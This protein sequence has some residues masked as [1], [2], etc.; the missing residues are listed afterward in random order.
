MMR[1]CLKCSKVK[2][3]SA[4]SLPP[5]PHVPLG[6][7]RPELPDEVK[8]TIDKALSKNPLDRPE[9]AFE[10][11]RSLTGSFI[12]SPT[13]G[14]FDP[15]VVKGE[16]NQPT[17]RTRNTHGRNR[18]NALLLLAILTVLAVGAW[19]FRSRAERHV[20]AVTAAK[21]TP[22]KPISVT[23]ETV[24]DIPVAAAPTPPPLVIPEPAPSVDDRKMGHATGTT[25]SPREDALLH[26][27]KALFKKQKYDQVLDFAD[28]NR[29]SVT[30]TRGGSALAR[31]AALSA[32]HDGDFQKATAWFSRIKSREFR[33]EVSTLCRKKG[34][35]L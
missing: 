1:A 8:S 25:T 6:T 4:N 18:K 29:F 27:A 24:V 20:A 16:P 5:T 31:L 7:R 19:L 34:L 35:H 33:K 10:F 22:E 32:C 2:A 11:W 21:P 3:W 14:G 30:S 12:P 13:D 28:R 15:T 9:D 26:E 23:T 17:V